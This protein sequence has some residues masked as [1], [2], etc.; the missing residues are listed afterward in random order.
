VS[1]DPPCDLPE[2][3]VSASFGS[4]RMHS[5]ARRGDARGLLPAE[6]LGRRRATIQHSPS[7]TPAFTGYS[8]SRSDNRCTGTPNALFELFRS[9]SVSR[10]AM[11]VLR[12]IA[13]VAA[14]STR[15][16]LGCRAGVRRGHARCSHLKI[17]FERWGPFSLSS[18]SPPYWE[19]RCTG[20]AVAPEAVRLPSP[21]G[22]ASRSKQHRSRP[23]PEAERGGR[24]RDVQA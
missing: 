19:C 10:R 2:G 3:V 1:C 8:S 6:V 13:R 16:G 14:P 20:A 21:A 9:Q 22:G 4:T 23:M 18:P 11:R 17:D 12:D 7:D 5:T 15:R 24:K